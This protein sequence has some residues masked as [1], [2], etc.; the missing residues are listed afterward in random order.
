MTRTNETQT[1]HHDVNLAAIVVPTSMRPVF[2]PDEETSLRHLIH[3]LGNYD[4][5]FVVP[6]RT[7]LSRPG[8]GVE[9]FPARYFGS[10]LAH[11]RLMMSEQFF[12]RFR[13][14]KYILMHHLDALVLSDR[15]AQWCE[16]DLD[17]IGAPWLLCDESPGVDRSRVGNGG[18]ALMKVES[19]LNVLRSRRPAVDPEEYW[20]KLC[21]VTPPLRRWLQLPWRYFKRLAIFNDVRWDVRRWLWSHRG[22]GGM[23][24]YFWADEAVKYWPQFRVASFE[25]GLEFAFE[26][27]PRLCFELNNRRLPFGCH[28]W[29]RNDRTFWEPYLLRQMP[30]SH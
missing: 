4:R 11:V 1:L 5:Y 23:S 20:R 21:A 6:N 16:T 17:F 24:D 3:F 14:Y 2:S 15:L 7:S 19:A 9:P 12:A 8:F 27:A 28:A 30:F 22:M 29:A 25:Q 26:V 18:F 10:R 13:R